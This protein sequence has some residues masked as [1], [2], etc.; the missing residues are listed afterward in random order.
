ME[1]Y[2][3]ANINKYTFSIPHT[4]LLL[5]IFTVYLHKLLSFLFHTI[6][7]KLD[8]SQLD[9]RRYVVTVIV[10]IVTVL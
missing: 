8:Y 9:I 5:L 7:E 10:I 2:F 6:T 3:Y 1:Y 4:F